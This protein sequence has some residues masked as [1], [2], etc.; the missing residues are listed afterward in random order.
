MKRLT[1]F[2]ARL[3]PSVWRQRYG[4][5]FDALL[6]DAAPKPRDAFDILWGAFRM[7]LSTWA[8]WRITLACALTGLLASLTISLTLPVTYRSHATL[9]VTPILLVE[10]L[11]SM[12]RDGCTSLG[13]GWW[14]CAVQETPALQRTMSESVMKLTQN[15]L[16]SNSLTKII[17]QNNL[18]P[19]E[20]ARKPLDELA[21]NM[22][23]NIV[24]T[25]FPAE[26]PANRRPAIVVFFNYPDAHVAQQVT[27]ELMWRL[28]EA[29][30]GQ[31]SLENRRQNVPGVL[32]PA[33]HPQADGRLYSH[34][35]MRLEMLAFPTL[36]TRPDRPNRATIAGAGLFAGLLAGLALATL[37]RSRRRT[38]AFRPHASEP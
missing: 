22:R 24:V 25:P 11:D 35:E 20:R 30:F 29:N 7:Q 31:I 6:E 23:K 17:Q 21:G 32:Y 36:P 13:G 10:D 38:A 18:Y 28:I 1:R 5:E 33:R 8:F 12:F 2:L 15:V 4:P 37:I 27:K 14:K 9:R 19:R 34:S 3:Y 16:S 26:Y